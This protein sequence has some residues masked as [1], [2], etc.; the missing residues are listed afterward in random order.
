MYYSSLLLQNIK[1]PDV[2]MM[3]STAYL[4]KRLK[5]TCGRP[6]IITVEWSSEKVFWCHLRISNYRENSQE[7]M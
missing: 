3:L 6:K 7:N 2:I 4:H 1:L 5:F